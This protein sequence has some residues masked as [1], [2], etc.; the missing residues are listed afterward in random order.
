MESLGQDAGQSGGRRL[1][2]A[3]IEDMEAAAIEFG[4]KRAQQRSLAGPGFSQEQGIGTPLSE[5]GF[6]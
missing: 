1:T 4:I 6:K 2:M 3:E 5:S